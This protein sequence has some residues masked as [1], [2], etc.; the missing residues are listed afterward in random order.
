M[1]RP[2]TA[3]RGLRPPQRARPGASAP[4]PVAALGVVC[5]G[6]TYFDVVQALAD[7]GVGVADLPGG[8]YGC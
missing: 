5:A 3:A 1:Q 6:K 7:L 4:R 8:A 2:L